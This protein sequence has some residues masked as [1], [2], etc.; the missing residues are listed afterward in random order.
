MVSSG[1]FDE[2]GKSR[3]GDTAQGDAVNKFDLIDNPAG[4]P[5]RINALPELRFQ[6]RLNVTRALFE[7]IADAGWEER[8][9]LLSGDRQAS[10]TDLI[11]E[12][13]GYTAVLRRHGVGPGIRVMLR[14]TDS[15]GATGTG[16]TVL[17][18]G[19]GAPL[20]THE[21][22]QPIAQPESA[23]GAAPPE[24]SPGHPEQVEPR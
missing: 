15:D 6:E 9:A 10:Y 17:H 8:L 5:T 2:P 22:V 24:S 11:Q 12:T 14:I 16:Y 13:A 19:Q 18:Q 1:P 3:N 21:P 23:Q 7:R 20:S 4:M